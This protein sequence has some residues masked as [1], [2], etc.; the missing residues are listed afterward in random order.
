MPR[1]TRGSP[2]AGQIGYLSGE[3]ES[4]LARALITAYDLD[5]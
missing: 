1:S 3:P 2:Q 5:L 4:A